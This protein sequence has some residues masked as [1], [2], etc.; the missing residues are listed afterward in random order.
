MMKSV[1]TMSTI[2]IMIGGTAWMI[3]ASQTAAGQTDPNMQAQ[4]EPTTEATPATPPA[5]PTTAAPSGGEEM[6]GR[7]VFDSSGH[8]VGT[9]KEIAAAEDGSQV[10][11]VSVGGFMGIGARRIAISLGT[12]SPLE[13]GSGYITSMSGEEIDAAPSVGQ[14]EP[15]TE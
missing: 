1:A 8:R 12:L 11:I 6:I 2:A 3:A 5:T 13:D 15:S 10:A 4:E 14:T 7:G 9:I